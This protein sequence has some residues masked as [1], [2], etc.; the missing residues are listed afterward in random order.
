MSKT[1]SSRVDCSGEDTKER[2]KQITTPVC[3][4][5]ITCNSLVK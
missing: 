3:V 5:R 1:M 4:I 2:R